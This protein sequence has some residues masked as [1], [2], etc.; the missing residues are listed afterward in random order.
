MKYTVMSIAG[1]DSGSGAGIQADLKTIMMHDLWGVCVITS[2]TA[3]NTKKIKKIYRLPLDIIESQLDALLE[4]YDIRTIKIGMLLSPE[5]IELVS[6]KIKNLGIDIIID[7]VMRS[8]S[9]TDLIKGDYVSTLCKSLIPYST[10]ITPNIEEA[11]ILSQIEI[12]NQ[13]DVKEACKKIIELGTK[14]VIIKGGH[15]NPS[16]S[17]VFDTLYYSKKFYYFKKKRVKGNFHGLGCTFSSSIACNIA[18]GYDIVSS[19]KLSE[20]FIENVINNSIKI[21][22]GL[23][24]VNQ[25]YI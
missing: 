4:D 14:S 23:I 7:P 16:I 6:N 20:V 11:K 21:A 2:I 19:V 17:E 18:K 15:I 10:M 13:S 12:S 8:T 24:P 22:H 5:I 25:K 9:G 3:Q 1:S